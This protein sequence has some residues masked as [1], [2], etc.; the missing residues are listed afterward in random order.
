[1]NNRRMVRFIDGVTSFYEGLNA[2]LTE[3]DRLEKNVNGFDAALNTP[4]GVAETARQSVM[5]SRENDNKDLQAHYEAIGDLL[6]RQRMLVNSMNTYLNM[7]EAQVAEYE[8]DYEK[9]RDRIKNEKISE[10]R[11]EPYTKEI[12]ENYR[13]VP[14][15]KAAAQ[16]IRDYRA[17]VSTMSDDWTRSRSVENLNKMIEKANSTLIEM[18]KARTEHAPVNVT[19]EELDPETQKVN[20]FV[21]GRKTSVKVPT[22]Q[23]S[24]DVVNRI[25]DKS[26]TTIEREKV[27]ETPVVV[28]LPNGEQINTTVKDMGIV[29]AARMNEI[30]AAQVEAPVVTETPVVE[31][32]ITEE[33]PVVEEVVTEEAPVVIPVVGGDDEEELEVEEEVLEEAPVVVPVVGGDDEEELEAE[34]D[35]DLDLLGALAGVQPIYRDLDLPENEQQVVAQQVVEPVTE[36]EILEDVEE[37]VTDEVSDAVEEVASEEAPVVI[38]VVGGDDV[39]ELEVVE[40][41]EEVLDDGIPVITDSA[42]EGE[43]PVITDEEEVLEEIPEI[44]EEE[45]KKTS[46]FDRFRKPKKDNEELEVLEEAPKNMLR[47]K[48]AR[49]SN[50]IK[51]APAALAVVAAVGFGF[52]KNAALAAAFAAGAVVWE[53]LHAV[54]NLCRQG[55]VSWKIRK[56]LKAVDGYKLDISDVGPLVIDK[57]LAEISNAADIATINEALRDKLEDDLAD[58]TDLKSVYERAGVKAPK[59]IL[60]RLGIETT[61]EDDDRQ[62]A[63]VEEDEVLEPEVVAEDSGVDLELIRQLTDE[64]NHEKAHSNDSLDYIANIVASEGTTA[65]DIANAIQSIVG[66]DGKISFTDADL[67]Y[68]LYQVN[69]TGNHDASIEVFMNYVKDNGLTVKEEKG[70]PRL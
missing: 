36:E 39:E 18:D 13:K 51:H 27:E 35:D 47:V 41:E 34:E 23:Y 54:Q 63:L 61:Y 56:A 67:E 1:M 17:A 2:Q 53:G 24:E 44:A 11:K 21:D 52:A 49:K 32:V 55:A 40:E 14:E 8:E 68:I 3:T 28:T 30:L 50:L 45:P 59:S 12:I 6:N 9:L 20:V 65:D 48:S 25:I 29:V 66:T 16:L 19:V 62:D 43:I 5:Q 22:D 42:V 15:L 31:E 69:M 37:V 60:S 46:F 4:N 70:G 38:P 33:E 57:D 64:K 10:L 7:I 58:C 26:V